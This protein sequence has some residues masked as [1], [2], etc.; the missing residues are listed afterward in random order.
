MGK[1]CPS[2]SGY[3]VFSGTLKGVIYFTNHSYSFVKIV[4][5]ISMVWTEMFAFFIQEL[6]GSFVFSQVLSTH[7]MYA[8]TKSKSRHTD[9]EVV[10][11]LSS[12]IIS[13][14]VCIIFLASHMQR[15]FKICFCLYSQS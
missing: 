5:W 12:W 3:F 10:N 8:H 9:V 13:L 15:H 4:F 11:E 14:W 6:I 2:Y 7:L 1:A